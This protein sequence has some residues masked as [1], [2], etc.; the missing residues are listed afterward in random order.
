VAEPARRP[1]HIA[2]GAVFHAREDIRI[3]A[4]ASSRLVIANCSLRFD[5]AT[6]ASQTRSA[7]PQ[8][9]SPSGGWGNVSWTMR[10][11]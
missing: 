1:T 7:L 5:Q 11:Q 8:L 2:E 10:E 6:K 9:T 3:L 4:T